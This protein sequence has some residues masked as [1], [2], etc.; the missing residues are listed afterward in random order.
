M[1]T[2]N[3]YSPSWT[4]QNDQVHPK[5]GLFHHMTLAASPSRAPMELLVGMKLP[6][7]EESKIETL[8]AFSRLGIPLSA[9]PPC[10]SKM[11]GSTVCFSL[12]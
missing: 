2:Q 9:I 12:Q 7:R 5:K 4:E 1:I 10:A 8:D 11:Q 6:S 3:S